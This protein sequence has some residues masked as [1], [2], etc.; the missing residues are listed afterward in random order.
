MP[1]KTDFTAKV[2][3]TLTEKR[4]DTVA[5]ISNDSDDSIPIVALIKEDIEK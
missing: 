2:W 5:F 1:N 3:I 4:I